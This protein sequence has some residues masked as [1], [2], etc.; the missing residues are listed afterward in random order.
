MIFDFSG[1]FARWE[2]FAW[3]AAMT[4]SLSVGAMLLG[5]AVGMFGAIARL[6][7]RPVLRAVVGCYVEL[8]RNTPF[9]VQLYIVYFG[10]PALGLR[11]GPV[12][13]SLLSLTVY[14]G[15]YLTELLRAG[16]QNVPRTQLEAAQALGLSWFRQIRHVVAPQALAAL[17]PALVSQF[18]LLML[19]S[20]I[21]SSVSTQELTGAAND[22]QGQTFRSFEA[23]LVVAAIY[24]VLTGALRAALMALDR[25]VFAFRYATR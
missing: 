25:R 19:A 3:G 5:M 21:V 23:F 7:R 11:F 1:T 4:L 8:I 20:S 2:L 12:T 9:L 6:S 22:I 10:L 17:Y 13:A 15:A 24:M 14:V 18:V 16:L